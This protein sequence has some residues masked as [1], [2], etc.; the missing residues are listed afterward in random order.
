MAPTAPIVNHLPF[1]DDSL[2]LF[3]AS[4]DGAVAVSNLLDIYCNASGQR[5]NNG[6]SSIF[7]VRDALKQ[8]G[9]A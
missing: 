3:R 1:D 7:S 9:M 6:K 8:C 2:L 4:N 5:V